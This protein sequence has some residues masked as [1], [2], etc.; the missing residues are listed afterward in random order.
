MFSFCIHFCTWLCSVVIRALFLITHAA[1][2]EM[3]C[4]SVQ[5]SPQGNRPEVYQLSQESSTV[6]L[7]YVYFA[8]PSFMF[9]VVFCYFYGNLLC[10]NDRKKS[11]LFHFHGVK[12]HVTEECQECLQRPNKILVWNAWPITDARFEVYIPKMKFCLTYVCYIFGWSVKRWSVYD[13]R[14]GAISQKAII[15]NFLKLT[16][17]AGGGYVGW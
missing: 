6:Y 12:Q 17:C 11:V 3:F 14:Q 8:L 4:L 1:K 15:F 13:R 2:E 9:I 5:V 16:S 7:L 10:D